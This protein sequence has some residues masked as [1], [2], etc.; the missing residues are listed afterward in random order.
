MNRLIIFGLC[1]TLIS[2]QPV[3]GY[4][5]PNTGGMLFQL[6]AIVFAGLSGILFFFSRHLRAASARV[7]RVFRGW[8]SDLR[9]DLPTEEGQDS[10]TGNSPRTS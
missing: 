4:V 6:A 1:F 3:F 10:E 7:K 2:N 5:D 8:L 9:T